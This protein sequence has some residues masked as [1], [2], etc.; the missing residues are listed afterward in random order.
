MHGNTVKIGKMSKGIIGMIW[1][2]F[3]KV[4]CMILRTMCSILIVIYSIID[5]KTIKASW[6]IIHTCQ[7]FLYHFPNNNII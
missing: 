1:F 6:T 4:I 5:Y 7:D 3:I 2:K